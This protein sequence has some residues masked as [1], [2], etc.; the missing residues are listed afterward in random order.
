MALWIEKVTLPV[1]N[2]SHERFVG[3]KKLFD[4]CFV[5]VVK[6][7]EQNLERIAHVVSGAEFSRANNQLD[8]ASSS[9]F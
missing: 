5:A 1:D 8:E 9:R 2:H 3:D 4:G 6:P 7:G